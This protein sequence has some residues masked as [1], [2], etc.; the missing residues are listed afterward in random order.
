V[1]TALGVAAWATKALDSAG[2]LCLRALAVMPA[3]L[4]LLS[5]GTCLAQGQQT[6]T[7]E[8]EFTPAGKSPLNATAMNL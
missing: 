1:V 2:A 8:R 6:T 5:C 4:A 3:V 7:T